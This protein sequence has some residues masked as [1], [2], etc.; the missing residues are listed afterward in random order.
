MIKI[1]VLSKK[2]PYPLKDGETIAIYNLCKALSENGAEVTLL[3]MN[4]SKHYYAESGIPEGY[5]FFRA[6]Y[7]VDVDNRLRWYDAL[8]NLL[9]GKSYHIT[10][11]NSNAF[12]EKLTELI[13]THYFDFIQLETLYL[14]P[15]LKTIRAIS[16][17]KISMRAHN[18]EHEIWKRITDNEKS[19][20]KKWYLDLL[21]RQLYQYE[22]AKLNEYDLLVAISEKDLR[23]FKKL[24]L[25]KPSKSIP[26]GINPGQYCPD[27]TTFHREVVTCSFIGS[28]DWMP[29]IE[30]LS[31]FL[32]QVLPILRGHLGEK[33][34]H[35]AGRNTPDWLLRNELPELVVH[36]EVEDA[37]LFINNHQVMLVPLLSGSG[38]RAKIIEG[39]ALG[40]AV[41]TTSLGLE[42]IP[43][44][45]LSE[46]LVA[47][48]PEDFAA[49]LSKCLHRE[50]DLEAIGGRARQFIESNFNL[51]PIGAELLNAF[52]ELI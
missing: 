48:T 20:L 46:V 10:R 4:T 45:H 9:R 49:V 16:S 29:N 2:F 24:G 32:E 1:L 31:W 52:E 40:R 39:M 13:S 38:M 5:E 25:Q 36:G 26:I 18:V 28:L 41:I 51:V 44:T 15:Y 33:S 27:F 50:F 37:R 19:W 22:K 43:A 8:W 12:N 47:D 6:I 21:T 35:I 17:A 7:S 14:A 3:A 23:N 42:G 34:I 11:F 30:G